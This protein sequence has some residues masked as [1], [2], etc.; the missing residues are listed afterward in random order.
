MER[1]FRP[2]P[3]AFTLIEHDFAPEGQ[4][5]AEARVRVRGS[6]VRIRVHETA[7]R[8]R[9]VARAEND[10][11]SCMIIPEA[12]TVVLVPTAVVACYL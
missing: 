9:I 6:V 8:I 7:I 5:R 11:A 2:P 12:I 1:L 10:T 3:Y 4:T